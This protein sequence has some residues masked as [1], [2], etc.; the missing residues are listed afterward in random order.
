MGPKE[1]NQ[2]AKV[3]IKL[4]KYTAKKSQ[5]ISKSPITINNPKEETKSQHSATNTG[6]N[7]TNGHQRI[8]NLKDV[9]DKFEIA[10]VKA[11]QV[12]FS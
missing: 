6:P 2:L 1:S 4:S 3:E 12:P 11:E 7:L 5:P 8:Q 9:F 10:V